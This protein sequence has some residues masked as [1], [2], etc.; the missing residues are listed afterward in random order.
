MDRT[1]ENLS[2]REKPQV[3]IGLPVHNNARFLRQALDALLGQSFRNFQV[4][5]LDDGSTDESYSI[6]ER[7]AQMDD[8]ISLF[9]NTNNSGL[10]AA[11]NLVAALAGDKCDPKYFAWYSDHDFV[12]NDWLANLLQVR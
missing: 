12:S 6:L 10:I 3:C 8:R 9:R 11:W 4:I 2:I 7:Y 5:A 1:E